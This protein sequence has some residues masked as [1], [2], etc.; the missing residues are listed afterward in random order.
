MRG[1]M[2][3]RGFV[4]AGAGSSLAVGL[5]ASSTDASYQ[6]QDRRNESTDRSTTIRLPANYYQQFDADP[7]RDV[8]AEGYGGWKRAEIEISSDHTAVVVMHAWDCGTQ[9]DYPG[10]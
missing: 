10:W 3:R 7:G 2:T 6:T 9:T 1:G 4:R 5:T 8:P